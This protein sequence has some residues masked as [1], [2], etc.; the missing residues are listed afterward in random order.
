[1]ATHRE[2]LTVQP[3]EPDKSLA[4][5][6][7]TMTSDLSTLMRK[8]VELAKLETKEEISGAAKAAG[9]VDKLKA[10]TSLADVASAENVSV[11]TTFG[12]KRAGNR[13]TPL[14]ATAI[15][16]VFATPKDGAGSAEGA[17]PAEWI[18]FRVTDITV[19]EFDASS[20]EAKRIAEQIR[21]SLTEDLL[22]Q[23]VVRLQNDIGASVN[24]RA[25]RQAV[26]GGS[27]GDDN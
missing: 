26:A 19:P 15:S 7:A 18:V 24:Q 6:I 10:G 4:E 27:G 1:M 3:R 12:L 9:M 17:S 5:L 21:R 14:S 8:E 16:A 13:Q 23:Y 20:G 11:Q 2:D 25:L 22:A